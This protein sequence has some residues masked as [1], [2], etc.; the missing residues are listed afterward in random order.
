VRFLSEASDGFGIIRR[1]DESVKV[2]ISHTH[3]MALALAV[4]VAGPERTVQP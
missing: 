3:R 2:S 4:R 1:E